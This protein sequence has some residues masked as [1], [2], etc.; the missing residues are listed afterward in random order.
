V[1]QIQALTKDEKIVLLTGALKRAQDV[2]RR[3]MKREKIGTVR[4]SANAVLHEINNAL[5]AD[6]Q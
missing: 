4:S 1:T 6:Y 2:L 3:L 5:E